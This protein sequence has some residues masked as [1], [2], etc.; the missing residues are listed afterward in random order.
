MNLPIAPLAAVV[1]GALAALGVAAMPAAGL[2]SLVMD[3]GLPAVFP[4]AEPPLGLTARAAMALLTGGFAALFTWLA[5]FILVGTRSITLG[6]A[7]EVSDEEVPMPVLRRADAHPDAPPRPP[8][9]ATRDLGTPFLEVRAADTKASAEVDEVVAEPEKIEAPAEPLEQPLP[10]DLEQPLSAFDPDA[11]LAVPMP[12]PIKLPPI[13]RPAKPPVFEAHERFEVFELTP[14]VRKPAPVE[15]APAP[16][17]VPPAEPIARPETEASVHALLERLEKGVVRRSQAR[18]ATAKQA[19][20]GLE[21][22][23]ATLRNMARQ[24]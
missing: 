3:S 1:L 8:L 11:I 24:A 2:E 6:K 16:E 23:L 5:A 20:R 19:E 21:D 18:A 12:P 9:L 15:A 22:A 10:V 17:P 7:P 13:R 14:P 4:A